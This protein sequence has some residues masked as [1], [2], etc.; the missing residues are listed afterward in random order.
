MKITAEEKQRRER[1]EQL[2]RAAFE[3]GAMCA[4][5]LDP[6][7]MAMVAAGDGIVGSSIGILEAWNKGWTLAN[8]EAPVEG[9]E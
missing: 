8:L 9:C 2:G 7:M 3:R 4:P 1:A 5:C 6:D